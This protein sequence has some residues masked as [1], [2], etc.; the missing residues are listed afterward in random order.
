MPTVNGR[1]THIQLNL[2]LQTAVLLADLWRSILDARLV[3]GYDAAAIGLLRWHHRHL[4]NLI[5]LLRLLRLLSLLIL[6]LE[7]LLILAVALGSFIL[8]LYRLV[9]LRTLLLLI[10]IL[11]LGSGRKSSANCVRSLRE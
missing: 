9:L 6:A 10:L 8:A 5:L 7:G 11:F 4:L 2:D 3:D 1:Y